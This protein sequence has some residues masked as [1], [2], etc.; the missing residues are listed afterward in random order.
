M[1]ILAHALSSSLIAI[2]VTKTSKE[3]VYYLLIALIVAAIPDLDHIFFL[4]RDWKTFRKVGLAGNLHKARSFFHEVLGIIIMGVISF[5]A[6]FINLKIG[7]IIFL[8]FIIHITQ[9]MIVGI[10]IPFA[11]VDKNEMKM[12][13]FNFRQKLLID[14][15]I[16]FIFGLLWIKFLNGH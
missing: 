6:S 2:T 12:F 4:I 13:S 15:S 16:I 3:Q 5:L 11:P 14:V 1:T 9:D 8:S 10:S 7:Q